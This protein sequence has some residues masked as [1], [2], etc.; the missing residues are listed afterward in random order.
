MR[1]EPLP[2][3]KRSLTNMMRL[4]RNFVRDE[5]GED[6]IE[7]GLLAAFVAGVALLVLTSPALRTA[8]SG[9]FQKAISVLGIV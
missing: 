1:R 2:Q 3:S 5:K 7:Y 6:L 9:A 4:I 8:I